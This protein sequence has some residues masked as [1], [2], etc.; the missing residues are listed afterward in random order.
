MFNLL[1]F[2]VDQVLVLSRS[3]L[4]KRKLLLGRWARAPPPLFGT[5]GSPV[6]GPQLFAQRFRTVHYHAVKKIR[7]FIQTCKPLIDCPEA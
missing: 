6:L 2:L 3:C 5:R 1:C 4:H 7:P